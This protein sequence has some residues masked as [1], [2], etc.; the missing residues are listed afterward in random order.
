MTERLLIII[1]SFRSQETV[2]ET[3]ED[4]CEQLTTYEL[5]FAL[6]CLIEEVEA[7]IKI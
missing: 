3:L 2:F 5:L 1:N 4:T 7:K 6:L